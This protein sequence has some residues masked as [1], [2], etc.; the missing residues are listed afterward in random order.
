MMIATMKCSVCGGCCTT[1]YLDKVT[2]CNSHLTFQKP[3]REI[4]KHD[5]TKHYNV[6]GIETIDYIK[7]KLTKEELKGFN[8]GN[9]IKYLSRAGHKGD[10]KEDYK[11]ALYYLEK[12]IN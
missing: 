10:E 5:E 1:E 8:K 11:K 4:E 12:L 6:G 2:C 3:K 7:A 9:V